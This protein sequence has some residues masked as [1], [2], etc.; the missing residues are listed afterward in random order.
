VANWSDLLQGA[1]PL[2]TFD[3]AQVK[4][5]LRIEWVLARRGVILEPSPDGRLVGLC[6]FHDDSSP[7][8]ALFGEGHQMAG[9]W[10][11]SFGHGDVFDVV[12]AL[13]Q[14]PFTQALQIAGRMVEEFKQD[15][16]WVSLAGELSPR[17]KSDPHDLT[18]IA[19]SAHLL[20]QTDDTALR[21]LID[22]KAQT[23]PGWRSITPEF[24][25]HQWWIGVE[26]D[27]TVT[28]PHFSDRG[29]GYP[30]ARGIKT[31]TPRSHL[32]AQ[33]GSDLSD[34]YGVWRLRGF[35]TILISEGESDSWCASAVLGDQLDVL[36]LPSGSAA[37]VQSQWLELFRGKTVILGMDGDKAGR[38]AAKKW[39]RSLLGVSS[40]TRIVTMGDGQDLARSHDLVRAVME[41]STV[42]PSVGN[43][44][45]PKGLVYYR[46]G[47]GD[48]GNTAISNWA[49]HPE[50]ELA[51]PDGTK[52]Y[53]GQV[54]R[55]SVV[56][57]SQDLSSTSSVKGWASRVGGN[58][59]GTD[60][61]AQNLLGLLQSEGP[62]L[63]RGRATSVIGLHDNHFVYPDGYIGPDYWR[64][65]KPPASFSL[66]TLHIEPSEG[67]DRD[68]IQRMTA[69]HRR[70]IVDPIIAW[71]FAAPL[72]SQFPVFPFLA[73]TGTAGT[74]KTTLV[75][76]ILDA[77]GWKIHTTLTSTT[78]HGVQSF[79]G[80][81][82]GI[83]VWFDEYRNAARPDSKQ[84]LDQVLRDAYNGT[85]SYKGGGSEHNR[86]S[87]TEMPTTSPIIVTGED[88]F[89]ET[90]HFERMVLVKLDKMYRSSDGLR[91]LRNAKSKGFGYA[92]LNWLMVRFRE[93]DLP[94]MSIPI[95][96]GRINTNRRILEIGWSLARMFHQDITGHDL[97]DPDFGKTHI[98]ID[99]ATSTD[100]IIEAMVWAKA[101]TFFHGPAVW[102]EADNV[103]VRA[104]NFVSEVIKARIHLL[105]G[106]VKAIVDYLETNWQAIIFN[107]PGYGRVYCLPGHASRLQD[108]IAPAP[109]QD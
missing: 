21:R 3:K 52:G 9:C 12:Q 83:P 30:L 106:G 86:L 39:Y 77:L 87:L 99:V 16:G 38:T 37:A 41:A 104:E 28:V 84:Q 73:V 95:E 2:R 34:M 89:S 45:S 81:T 88:A 15:E 65:M 14:V 40:E 78:P 82:N 1:D 63:A 70:E 53:E 23:D 13:F 47:S 66:N 109:D 31:R 108:A 69:L 32:Y 33:A 67:W 8:F 58:W 93:G 51:F 75:E 43:V 62:F 50:R 20:A 64:Y 94:T 46:M 80:A 6:P 91:E 71:M 107:H 100:P 55:S 54:G 18:G 79:A 72:R 11:C 98:D 17:P 26:D 10:T 96:H 25:V 48:T 4:A 97:G 7:S 103:Y 85:P 68:L 102:A 42:R 35:D 27:W 105:P 56:L 57:Q 59:T 49:L 60:K 90:S 74:G 36:G 5:D 92:Y 76:S 24:L 29:E 101:Q 22:E 61:D 19:R 44:D